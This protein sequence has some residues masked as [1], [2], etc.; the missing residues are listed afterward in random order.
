MPS[1]ETVCPECG[2]PVGLMNPYNGPMARK[3][4]RKTSAHSVPRPPG[5]RSGRLPRCTGSGL[6]VPDVA[7]YEV[8]D[9]AG[10][11]GR[12]R[13]RRQASSPQEASG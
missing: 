3:G 9:D 2:Q 5:Y 4:L 10:Q 12:R 6:E 11:A 7:I 13:R 1:L 8:A